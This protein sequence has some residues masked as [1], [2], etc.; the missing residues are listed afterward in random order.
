MIPAFLILA[1]TA[2]CQPL[3]QAGP[4]PAGP[5]GPVPLLESRVDTGA[6]SGVRG[7]DAEIAVYR[8][9]PYAKPP[10]G[11]LRLRPPQR[12]A[13]WE[14]VRDASAFG[15]VCPQHLRSPIDLPMDE[16]CLTANIWT[17]ASSAAEHRPV[18]VWIY[19]GGFN[20]GY[21]ADPNF[22]GEA[23]ARKGLVV[24]PYNYRLGPLGF[25]STPELSAESGDGSSGNYG[26]L[27]SIALLKWVKRN[28]AAF[29]GDPDNVTIAGQSAGAGSVQFLSLSPISQGLFRHAISQSQVRD[30]GDPALRYLATSYRHR[31]TALEQGAAYASA[32]GASSPA[33]LRQLDWR[34]L[35]EGSTAMDMSIDSGSWA[36]PPLFRPVQDGVV[37]P[38]SVSY[39]LSSG[40]LPDITY[41]AG[42]N[43][44][45]SGAVPET[46]FAKRRSEGQ[47]P[48]A[49]LPPTQLTLTDYRAWA[50]R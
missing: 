18:F 8:G 47:Q 20:E 30:P 40:P 37:I 36:K 15:P 16:D 21:G 28:I 24:I 27:D 12:P 49:G 22:D 10:T 43:R 48:R 45:E 11:D 1:A 7:R 14:G 33:Q 25:L 26:L 3:A 39:A 5:N 44:D 32:H 29:G 17:A 50:E 2:A 19:G 9:I 35:M 42:N 23:L 41:V 4:Q 38:T 31:D 34:K 6:L 46:S 13:A